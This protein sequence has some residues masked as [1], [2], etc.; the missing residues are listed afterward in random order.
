M[1]SCSSLCY[2]HYDTSA[3]NLFVEN[4]RYTFEDD[5]QKVSY[6]F[7]RSGGSSTFIFE[8]KTTSNLYVDLWKSHLIINGFAYSYY[9][10]QSYLM[11]MADGESKDRKSK[12]VQGLVTSY[13]D[14]A[15]ESVAAFSSPLGLMHPQSD[16]RSMVFDGE[17][18]VI[19]PPKAKKV[20]TGLPLNNK[21]IKD[22]K[23]KHFPE[24][25]QSYLAFTN[26]NSPLSFRNRIAYQMEGDSTSQ[27]LSN[28]WYVSK[29]TNLRKKEYHPK[30]ADAKT[31]QKPYKDARSFFISY[32][33]KKKE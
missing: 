11:A 3:D 29:I 19:I 27:Y 4:D 33:V 13:V 2:Q 7:Y 20:I 31:E 28:E 24:N 21:V 14:L 16:N 6:D 32:S 18:T 23:L 26:E 1:V 30:N 12:N 5:Q 22:A 9:E 10:N 8:N 15:F 25:G 17:K